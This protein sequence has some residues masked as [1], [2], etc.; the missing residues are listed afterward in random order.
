MPAGWR[1][2]V[3]LGG[4]RYPIGGPDVFGR[5]MSGWRSGDQRGFTLIELL[6]VMALTA[7]L[8][9][10]GASAVRHYWFVRS[11][12]GAQDEI[13][14]QLRRSQQQSVAESHPRTYGAR[15]PTRRG[16][17]MSTFGL[18]RLNIAA[19][20]A[21]STCVEYE[22]RTF[23]AGVRIVNPGGSSTTSFDVVPETLLCRNQIP[24]ASDKD[25]FVFFRARGTATAGKVTIDHPVLGG[26]RRK[27]VCVSA[28]TGRIE[29]RDG[30]SC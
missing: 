17:T 24:G 1:R 10:L 9:T 21:A 12:Q 8:M 6:V 2:Q 20:P 11:L 30:T 18:V 28:L 3:L 4:G 14:T 25:D 5:G 19:D 16:S 27:T 29:G 23:D 13:V 7:V 26:S 22:S 15:F